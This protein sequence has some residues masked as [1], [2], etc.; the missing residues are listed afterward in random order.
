MPEY[1]RVILGQTASKLGFVRDTFE[2]MSRLIEILHFINSDVVI[3]L[4]LP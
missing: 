2:K 4:Y 3:N 1:N